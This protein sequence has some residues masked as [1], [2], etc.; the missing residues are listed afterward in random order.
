M[1]GVLALGPF[2]SQST[3]LIYDLQSVS[4]MLA[5]DDTTPQSCDI[6]HFSSVTMT[7]LAGELHTDLGASAKEFG[8]WSPGQPFTPYSVRQQTSGSADGC[9]VHCYEVVAS[10]SSHVPNMVVQR[11]SVCRPKF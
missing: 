3:S 11:S 6:K 4:Q 5:G 7:N 8:L 1:V 2:P 10:Y 9:K